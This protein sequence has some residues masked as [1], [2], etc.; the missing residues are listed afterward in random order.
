MSKGNL[1][2][3][4][5]YIIL[6]ANRYVLLLQYFVEAGAMAVRRCKKADLKRI[7]KATG[8]TLLSSMANLEGISLL[9]RLF[10]STKT[11]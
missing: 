3:D 1:S 11:I 5:I 9:L 10:F 8:A 2:V 6:F 7:A 4:N